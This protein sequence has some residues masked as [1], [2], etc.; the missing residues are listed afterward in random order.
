[1]DILTTMF[2]LTLAA[3]LGGVVGIERENK[4]RPAGFRTHILVCVG[5]ALVMV[6]SEYI[7]QHYQGKTTLD[8]ARL[9]AQVISGIGFL[10][11]GTIIREGMSVKGLTTAASLWAVACI[12]L[13]AG[14]GFYA[15]AV[16]GTVLIYLTLFLL[17]KL[18]GSLRKKV[19][20]S[21]ILKA[22]NNPAKLGEI[23]ALLNKYG[24]TVR[25]MEFIIDNDENSLNENIANEHI[26]IRYLLELPK[27]LSSLMITG[28]LNELQGI[29]A[30]REE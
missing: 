6:T 15:G 24:V 26:H 11:A 22:E 27:G 23:W 30:A 2:K 5:S 17:R 13:A 9:G 4:Q 16:Y 20:L 25:N 1:M 28:K 10:G 7:F 3:L 19:P 14:I 18:E 29:D 21:V 12:G 8:P